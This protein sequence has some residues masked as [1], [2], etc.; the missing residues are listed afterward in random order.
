MTH[1]P[2]IVTASVAPELVQAYYATRQTSAGLSPVVCSTGVELACQ[3][4]A[5]L[6]PLDPGATDPAEAQIPGADGLW[7]A[8]TP[9]HLDV[10][11]ALIDTIIADDLS[12]ALYSQVALQ[13]SGSGGS[14]TAADLVPP[15]SVGAV[16][17]MDLGPLPA[18]RYVVVIRQVFSVPPDRYGLYESWKAIGLQVGS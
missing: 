17:F 16:A 15:V 14:W 10:A 7:P 11:G 13:A 5:A 1:G 18:G 4:I 6:E 3:G 9:A 12:P 8:L 2:W